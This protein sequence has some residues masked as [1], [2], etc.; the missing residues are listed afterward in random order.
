M[1]L[2]ELTIE[3]VRNL[4]RNTLAFVPGINLIV[5]ENGSGKTSLLEAVYLIAR[6]QSFRS[7]RLERVIAHSAEALSVTARLQAEHVSLTTVGLHRHRDGEK[8]LRLNGQSPASVGEIVR[9]L[10]LQL[11]NSDIF[12]WL[13]GSSLQRRR[14]LDWAVFH[15]EPQLMALW[16]RLRRVL[17]QRNACLRERASHS[18]IAAWNV[19][20]EAVAAQL[21]TARL[22]VVHEWLA[23]TSRIAEQWFMLPP[24]MLSYS[25]GWPEHQTLGQAL[26]SSYARDQALGYTQQGPHRAD[27]VVL[28]GK[29]PAREVLSLG[30][31]KLL[32]SAL[33]VALGRIL[34]RHTQQSCLFLLDDIAAE[35]DINNEIKL[36]KLLSSIE[37]QVLVTRTAQL[38]H[39][40]T[41]AGMFH[42]E[43][44]R[45]YRE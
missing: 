45:I 25:Q 31:Q 3:N 40:P 37:A 2:S 30:Q 34:Y 14:W 23:E 8:A 38:S 12:R 44:G 1:R 43:Q 10:P 24:L 29:L 5:G 6:G 9:L 20:W 35:L 36:M 17:A 27:I 21:N 7:T 11:L 42:V 15:V 13:Q 26:A 33:A 28:S 18:V 41:D 4:Q 16:S 22:Q 39:L 19:E 32:V